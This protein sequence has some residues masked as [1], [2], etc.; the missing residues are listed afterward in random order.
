MCTAVTAN[1]CSLLA[2]GTHASHGFHGMQPRAVHVRRGRTCV[3]AL[4]VMRILAGKVAGAEQGGEAA[5]IRCSP[6]DIS[7]LAV[8]GLLLGAALERIGCSQHL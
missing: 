7:S 8:C 2:T 5:G 4:R 1:A 3:A 6:L